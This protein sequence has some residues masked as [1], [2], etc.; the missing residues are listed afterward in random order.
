M[1]SWYRPLDLVP[2]LNE[3]RIDASHSLN[4]AIDLVIALS[5]LTRQRCP[6]DAWNTNDAGSGQ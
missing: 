3:H 4:D 1:R 2:A 6:H 5:G